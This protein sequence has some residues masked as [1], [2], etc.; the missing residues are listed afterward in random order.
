MKKLLTPIKIRDLEVRNRIVMTAMHLNYTPDGKVNDRLVAFY[1]ERSKG[2]TGLIIVGGC[3]INDLAGPHWLIDMR[4][5]SVIE[6]HSMLADAI[7]KHGTAAVCQ[8]YHAGR[9]SHSISMGGKQ[10]VAPSAVTARLTRE[11]PRAMSIEEIKQTVRDYAEAAV[12]IK[13]AGYD[14]VEVLACTGYLINQFMSPV[15][16]LRDDEYGGSWEN[17]IRFGLEVADAVGGEPPTPKE[18]A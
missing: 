12:R 10:A 1:E 17:R 16:N 9:Y 8:L 3:I 4:D 2:G 11:E 14:A 5:D 7:K 13:K 6:G 18:L 15:T